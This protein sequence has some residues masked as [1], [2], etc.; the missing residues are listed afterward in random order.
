MGC[1][2]ARALELHKS[3]VLLQIQAY[4]HFGGS[5]ALLTRVRKTFAQVP[6]LGVWGPS[7]DQPKWTLE[8]VFLQD[9]N[10]ER[11]LVAVWQTDGIVWAMAESVVERKRTQDYSV[12]RLGWSIDSLA[13][14][15]AY[16]QGLL[17][18]RDTSI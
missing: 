12:N 9:L 6:D 18:L 11:S 17:V 15:S 10:P 5:P 4:A 7:V 1:K 16:A 2:F 8:K 3:E 14:A 13:I